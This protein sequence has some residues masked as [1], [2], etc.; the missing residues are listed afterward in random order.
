M[1]RSLRIEYAGA[2]YHV[3][4]RGNQ[5]RRI[6]ADDGDRRM[7]LATLAE[8]WRRMGWRVHAYVL[9][10]NHYH[11][12]LETPEANL[13]SGMKWLQGTYTQRYN[14]RHRKRGHL[15]QGRYRGVVV[16]AEP[17][18]YFQT[19]ST[20]I[21]LNPARAELIRAGEHKLWEY[22]WSSYPSYARR[23]PPEWLTTGRVLASAGLRPG[24]RRGY[25]AYIEARV[26]ELGV[27]AGRKALE[28]AWAG[29]RRGW[30]VGEEEFGKGLL[31]RAREALLG[32]RP[33]SHAGGAK[34][35]HD[36]A[37]AQRL[38]GVGMDLL[39]LD[40]A[41]LAQTPKGQIEKLV[42]AWWVYGRT[43]VTRRWIAETLKMGYETRVSQAAR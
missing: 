14:A 29:L 30:Y 41:D 7:W 18:D 6:Y 35:A 2:I 31:A 24:D 1:S 39:G 20:Y 36:L 22:P 25:E 34:A 4:G 42:L 19:V 43:V 26:L 17:G 28:A 5:G 21:H 3:M 33:E 12:L 40:Q 8:A 38:V 37:H 11:L 16:A 9:M 32:K 13:V 27:R 10:D 15:F 23:A